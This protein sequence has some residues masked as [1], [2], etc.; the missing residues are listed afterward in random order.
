ARDRDGRAAAAL[1][2]SGRRYEFCGPAAAAAGRS[3]G[4]GRRT[5]RAPRSDPRIQRAPRRQ[6][7]ADRTHAGL[8]TPR[9]LAHEQVPARSLVSATGRVLAGPAAH[10]A[11]VLDYGARRVGESGSPDVVS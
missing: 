10:P 5:T 11:V 8:R 6:T 4:P 1:E 2:Y 9:H 3:R 7:R